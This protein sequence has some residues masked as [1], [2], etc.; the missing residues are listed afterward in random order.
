MTT[1]QLP[2]T[3]AAR[4]LVQGL[5]RGYQLVISPLLGPCCRF[6]P[7]CSQYAMEAVG[8]FGV[9]RGLA[10]AALRVARCHPWNPGGVD[11]VPQ[12]FPA[13]RPVPRALRPLPLR[14]A[15]AP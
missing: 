8:R 15:D 12:S 10:L 1:R 6:Y 4:S 5:L 3:R 13:W 9:V 14:R 7:S 2:V 11:P